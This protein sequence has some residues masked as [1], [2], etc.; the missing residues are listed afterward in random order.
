MIMLLFYLY[1]F[2][3]MLI[4]D[5]KV[6]WFKWDTAVDSSVNSNLLL[7]SRSDKNLIMYFKLK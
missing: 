3:A 1:V 5:N 2:K 7:W 4:R 6:R